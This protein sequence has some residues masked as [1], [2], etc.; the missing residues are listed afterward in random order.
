MMTAPLAD[1]LTRIRNAVATKKEHVDLPS[2]KMKSSVLAVMKKE[3]YI[4]N[5]SSRIDNKKSFTTVDL[6]YD[7]N[8]EIVQ[9]KENRRL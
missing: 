1:M 3:G 8:K 6:K 2:S 5:F 9:Q 4:S 7:S